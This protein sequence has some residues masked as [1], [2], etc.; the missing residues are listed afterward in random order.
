MKGQIVIS[1]VCH[2]MGEG[3]E[4]VVQIHLYLYIQIKN[5]HT[6]IHMFVY[7]DSMRLYYALCLLFLVLQTFLVTISFR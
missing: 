3:L 5:I 7:L 2:R 4:V 1:G 6:Y